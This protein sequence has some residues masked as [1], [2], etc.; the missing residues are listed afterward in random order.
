MAAPG[1]ASGASAGAP[2]AGVCPSVGFSSVRFGGREQA[3]AWIA[4]TLFGS[5]GTEPYRLLA[6]APR[7][8][9]ALEVLLS[10]RTGQ[11]VEASYASTEVGADGESWGAFSAPMELTLVRV[12]AVDATGTLA[13]E[14]AGSVFGPYG[15]VPMAAAGCASFRASP[16]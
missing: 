5:C 8:G 6:E 16:C 12:G 10:S 4:P 15:V 7:A 1:G 11:V 2:A 13:F 9:A 3:A 14:L